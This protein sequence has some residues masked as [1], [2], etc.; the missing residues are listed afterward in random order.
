MKTA[1]WFALVA[2]T[3]FSSANACSIAELR[4]IGDTPLDRLPS[5]AEHEFA[6]PRLSTEGGSWQVI[7]KEDGTPHSF[8]ITAMGETGQGRTRISFLKRH[9]FVIV[10]TAIRYA[11]PI[12]SK[13]RSESS[14]CSSQSTISFVMTKFK[15]LQAPRRKRR[16][17]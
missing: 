4:A 5:S 14:V 8:L 3:S 1:Y 13:N 10:Q 2:L 9:D 6:E 7:H 12:F 11:E 17:K 16:R 15:Y